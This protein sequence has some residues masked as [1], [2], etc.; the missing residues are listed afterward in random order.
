MLFKNLVFSN[1]KLRESTIP[2]PPNDANRYQIGLTG[3]VIHLIPMSMGINHMKMTHRNNPIKNN[4]YLH[5]FKFVS[6]LK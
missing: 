1:I 6:I 4:R 5:F 3:S 2:I